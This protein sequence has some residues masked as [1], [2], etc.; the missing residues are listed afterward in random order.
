MV[1]WGGYSRFGS[2]LFADGAAFSPGSATW[3][4]LPA[5]PLEAR[6]G[7]TT[8]WTGE[9][10]IVWGGEVATDGEN[11]G[12]DA[13]DG[14]S[15]DAA[16]NRWREISPSPLE[17]RSAHTAVWTGGEM[18][19]LGGVGEVRFAD[20]ASYD[21]SDD[22]WRP[23][24]ASP[25]GALSHHTA[26]W[27]GD[28]MIVWGGCRARAAQSD[29][30]ATYFPA[31]DSWEMLPTSPLAPRCD[32]ESVWTGR[33]LVVWGGER[34][35]S[36]QLA[37]GAAYDPATDRWR[38]LPGAPLDPRRGPVFQWTGTSLVVWGGSF[39]DYKGRSVSGPFA[40]GA[41]YDPV[42]NTWRALPPSPLEPRDYAA[43][44]W[45]GDAMIV[46]GGNDWQ[47]RTAFDDGAALRRE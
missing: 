2:R 23:I 32:A 40:D 42:E 24:D 41:E 16:Q 13:A 17:P 46:W 22:A 28:R 35:S 11:Y 36:R 39:D 9:E 37:D 26:V 6:T 27:A 1:V 21:P 12:A 8:V 15:Y 14:A 38:K 5:A 33:E 30:G 44:V 25:L 7:H 29:A 4:K 10:M 18:I 47:R 34:T 45:S 19:V 3:R 20:G 31:T 43:S